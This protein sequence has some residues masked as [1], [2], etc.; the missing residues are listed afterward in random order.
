MNFKIGEK[1][2]YLNEVG[3]GVVTRIIDDKT[4]EIENEYG[5]N[6]PVAKKELIKISEEETKEEDANIEINEAEKKQDPLTS[7][8]QE[9]M[10]SYVTSNSYNYAERDQ[11]DYIEENDKETNTEAII[12]DNKTNIYIAFVPESNKDI[13]DSDLKIFLINDSNY[14]ILYN[15]SIEQENEFINVDSGELEE[16][17]K[18]FISSYKIEDISKISNI[19]VQIIFYKKTY[20][21]PKPPINEIVKIKP[22]KFFKDNSFI[23]N[24]YFDNNAILIPVYSEK[25][26]IDNIEKLTK[27]DIKKIIEEKR[28]IKPD[29]SSKHKIKKIDKKQIVEVDLHINNL[30]D[31]HK[32]LSN[33][34]IINIQLNHFKKNLE[35]AIANKVE[36][37]VFIHGVG[38]GTLK[39]E[40]HKIL[41][42]SYP[43][44]P[45]QDASFKEYGYG[46]TMILIKH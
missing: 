27:H 25:E 40:I 14:Q 6:V 36:K 37:I 32:G 17:I 4:I 20:F 28:D 46:A 44:I 13:G 42:E 43:F 18:T 16:N 33:G 41:E 9:K 11:W 31:N 38:N 12:D 45:Y 22:T 2:R 35:N 1:V 21:S 8:E 3:G 10:E 26:F 5:F 7:S 24:D 30:I 19:L 23:E 15:V 34:E 29:T 39:F